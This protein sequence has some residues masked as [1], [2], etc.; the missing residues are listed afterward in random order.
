MHEVKLVKW[1][2]NSVATNH[3]NN[4]V[5]VYNETSTPKLNL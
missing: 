4:E 5:F 3:R 1:K 2:T